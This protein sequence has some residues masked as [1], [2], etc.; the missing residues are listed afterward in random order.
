[1]ENKKGLI[2]GIANEYSIAWG[3]TKALHEA[4]GELAITY[5]NE[6]TRG[7]VQPLAEK[8]S[9]PIVMPLDVTDKEQFDALFQKIKDRW[10]RLDFVIHAIAFAPKTD[11]QGRVVDCSKDGFM[12]AMDI[13]CH[14]LIRLA[15]AAEPL[16]VDGGSII[17]MSYYGAEKV[18][19]NYN[20]MGP[21]KAAL[22]TSVRYLAMELGSKKIRVNAI[23]P[24]PISTRAASGLAD[25]DTLMEQ[26]AKE[27]PLHQLVTI[28][29]IGETASFLVSDKAA[30][31]TGQTLYVDSGY[32]IK[33]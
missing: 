20:L 12:M 29:D 13:S 25:F 1:M 10:G 32:N 27:A 6:K 23:S 16:M 5:Q 18:V 30:S 19:K 7:Y 28:E 4:G 8:V 31:I 11:L 26:A 22:E 33:G 15:K 3:C 9:S 21:V 24:G 2:V 14:S 17:T